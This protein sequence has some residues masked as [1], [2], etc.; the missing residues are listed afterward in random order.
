MDKTKLYGVK[1]TPSG[2]KLIEIDN[3]LEALQKLVGG[4]IEAHTL[5]SPYPGKEAIVVICDEEGRL[6]GYDYC[7][8][9]CGLDFVGDIFVCGQNEDEFTDVPLCF[10]R[11]SGAI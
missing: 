8:T 11:D 6:K 9:I 2:S 7:I 4:Y 10:V 1:I 3:T 5:S